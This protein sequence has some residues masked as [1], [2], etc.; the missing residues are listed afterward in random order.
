MKKKLCRRLIESISL[1]LK[2]MEDYRRYLP[3]FHNDNISYIFNNIYSFKTSSFFYLSS[4]IID[5]LSAF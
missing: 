3:K 2:L 1:I 4:L 5:F